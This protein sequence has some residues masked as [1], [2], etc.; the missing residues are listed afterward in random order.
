MR[1]KS[2]NLR[3]RDILQPQDFI[4]MAEGIEAALVR[5]ESTS[6]HALLRIYK[7]GA[8]ASSRGVSPVE[9]SASRSR[10]WDGDNSLLTDEGEHVFLVYLCVPFHIHQLVVLIILGKALSSP[11]K[12]LLKNSFRWWMLWSGYMATSVGAYCNGRSGAAFPRL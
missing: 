2:P 6:N 8:N 5:F 4:E 7:K 10:S 3:A 9:M 1:A 12:N 11:F